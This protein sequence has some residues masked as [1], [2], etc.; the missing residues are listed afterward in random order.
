MNGPPLLLLLM[1]ALSILLK[2][3][4]CFA[5]HL[6]WEL[7]AVLST[8]YMWLQIKKKKNFL[9]RWTLAAAHGIQFLD[10]GSPP[11]PLHSECH[12]YWTTGEIL[13]LVTFLN[14]R[15]LQC[16]S[17]RDTRLK[18]SRTTSSRQPPHR[19]EQTHNSP[20]CS[21]GQSCPVF[22]NSQVSPGLLLLLHH[23]SPSPRFQL[24][25]FKY[26]LALPA[27][28]TAE[29]RGSVFTKK[30]GRCIYSTLTT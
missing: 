12:S 25:Y 24:Y 8:G 23:V 19:T 29:N 6:C 7:R 21:A 28:L 10:Q 1:W 14:L 13:W 26:I 2:C 18:C 3:C 22:H 20:I 17:S 27:L 11:G 30:Q 9:L 4:Q 5:G 16:S 15:H